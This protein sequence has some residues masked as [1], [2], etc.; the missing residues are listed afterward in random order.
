MQ[1]A[2]VTIKNYRCFQDT[3][4][5]K[6]EMGPGFTALV[7]P[8]NSGKSSCIKLF[9]ELYELWANLLS[10]NTLTTLIRGGT[11][12]ISYRDVYDSREIFCD[13]NVRPLSIEIELPD[14]PELHKQNEITGSITKVRLECDQASPGNWQAYFY[15]GQ[16]HQLI[17][18]NEDASFMYSLRA[19]FGGPAGRRIAEASNFEEWVRAIHNCLYIAPYRNAISEGSATYF[20]MNIGNAFIAT[21]NQWKTGNEKAQNLLANKVTEDIRR[22]FDFQKL[23]INA[24]QDVKTLALTIDGKPYKLRELGAGIAQFIL[25]LGNVAMRKPTL[26]LID[27]PE[28]NLHPTLQAD[29]LTTLAAYTTDGVI[30]AT[31]SLGLARATADRIYSFQKHGHTSITRIFEQTPN[32]VEFVGE[33][34]FGGY[35]EL[36]FD[37]RTQNCCT[38]SRWEPID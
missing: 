6:L 21:W 18:R 19:V 22:I 16:D 17:A 10:C 20:G 24:S 7:G 3:N 36:G 37:R 2:I 25:V 29:F 30:Y 31:H 4:P 35:R 26:L 23:E 9:H 28:L 13:I 33:L 11:I 8:N 38:A 14:R 15:E 5:L 1:R 34:S 27:E 32:Y 12:G